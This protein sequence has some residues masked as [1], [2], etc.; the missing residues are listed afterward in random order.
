[1]IAKAFIAATITA[2][3]GVLGLE[4]YTEV[5]DRIAAD[6]ATAQAEAY[7]RAARLAATAAGRTELLPEDLAAAAADVLPEDEATAPRFDRDRIVLDASVEGECRT[8]TIGARG[9][10][11]VTDC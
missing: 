11:V 5:A 4:A 10:P 9:E 8:V 2:S 1:M 7:A 3:L 6:A